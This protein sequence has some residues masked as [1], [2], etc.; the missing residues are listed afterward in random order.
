MKG[1]QPMKG[2][3]DLPLIEKRERRPWCTK[4]RAACGFLFVVV[5]AVLVDAALM[6]QLSIDVHDLYVDFTAESTL[7]IQSHHT[8]SSLSSLHTISISS[9]S[10]EIG[11]R[12]RS[13]LGRLDL[14][15]TDANHATVKG[16]D[17]EFEEL[18]HLFTSRSGATPAVA[19]T[20]TPAVHVFH[21]FAVDLPSD[22]FLLVE[23]GKKNTQGEP[24]EH[25]AKHAQPP[26][27]NSTLK[28][29]SNAKSDQSHQSNT[30]TS[31]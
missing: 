1:G 5:A 27:H 20:I 17:F 19:C 2:A 23:P 11:G 31:A 9:A 7:E 15:N 25:R 28:P 30:K 8:V 29:P 6:G 10:C 14:T 13:I 22:E 21:S 4:R 26:R 3:G 18:S 12:G 16:S 24:V